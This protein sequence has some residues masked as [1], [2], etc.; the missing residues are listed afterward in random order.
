MDRWLKCGS[1]KLKTHDNPSGSSVVENSASAMKFLPSKHHANIVHP[2]II[3]LHPVALYCSI[4][5]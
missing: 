2:N 3:L 5:F 1:L 4:T